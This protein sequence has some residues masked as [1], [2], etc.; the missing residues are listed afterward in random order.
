MGQTLDVNRA[1]K[2]RKKADRHSRSK[3]ADRHSRSI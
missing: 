2:K 1:P 3:K